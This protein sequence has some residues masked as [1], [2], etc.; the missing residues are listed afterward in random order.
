[1]NSIPL[2]Y[3]SSRISFLIAVKDGNRRP[4]KVF[5]LITLTVYWD[6]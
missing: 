2:L 1:L 4:A 6:R 5:I 3:S